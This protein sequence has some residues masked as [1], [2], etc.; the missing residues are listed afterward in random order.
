M[1]PFALATADTGLTTVAD[2]VGT[3]VKE[4]IMAVITS[5]VPVLLIVGASLI[6]VFLVWKIA[7]RFI[8]R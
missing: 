5:N 8:G 2:G 1:F 4:N 6:A 7:K 3:V